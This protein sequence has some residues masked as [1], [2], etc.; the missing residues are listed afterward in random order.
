MNICTPYK[1]YDWYFNL[2]W[3]FFQAQN[4]DSLYTLKI[5]KWGQRLWTD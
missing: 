4:V 2:F 3:D 1:M 5:S